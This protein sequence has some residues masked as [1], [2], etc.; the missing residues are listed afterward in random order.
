MFFSRENCPLV[1]VRLRTPFQQIVNIV[2][3]FA[4]SPLHSFIDLFTYLLLIIITHPAPQTQ[5]WSESRSVVSDSLRPHGL[6]SPCNSP[7]QD[8]EVGSLSLLQGIFPTQGLS[9][10]LPHCRRI[11]YQLS[12]KGSPQKQKLE[13]KCSGNSTTP[14]PLY[15]PLFLSRA[16]GWGWRSTND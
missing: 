1:H 2:K 16:L 12:C 9:P 10:G 14:T 7:G 15:W 13:L 3:S 11:L 4:F 8:T 5:K 6:Y